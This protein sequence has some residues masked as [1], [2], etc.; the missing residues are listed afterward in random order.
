MTYCVRKGIVVERA[1]TGLWMQI[2]M[3]LGKEKSV[4]TGES[5]KPKK[6]KLTES[7]HMRSE[8]QLT[9]ILFSI[10]TSR[11]ILNVSFRAFDTAL[12]SKNPSIA[13]FQRDLHS[14]LVF[15][16]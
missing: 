6:L 5:R 14:S 9:N 1:A 7:S 2:E 4:S 15:S 16:S 12:S 10:L 11:V 13:K 3:R 8:N